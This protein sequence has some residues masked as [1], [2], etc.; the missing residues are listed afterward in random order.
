MN[1]D[2]LLETYRCPSCGFYKSVLP[3]RIHEVERV[4]EAALQPIRLA[5][6]QQLLDKCA[7]LLNFRLT[8]PQSWMSDALTVVLRHRDN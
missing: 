3:V 1:P 4:D 2:V 7:E 8:V 5:N 6:F